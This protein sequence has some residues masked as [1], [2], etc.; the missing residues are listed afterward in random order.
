MPPAAATRP[1]SAG[2]G[3]VVDSLP[4]VLLEDE[5]WRV[6]ASL[7]EADGTCRGVEGAIPGKECA[8]PIIDVMESVPRFLLEFGLLLT[9]IAQPQT[10][11]QS[12]RSFSLVDHRVEPGLI[13]VG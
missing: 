5:G 11:N 9:R 3:V 13:R 12:R 1:V 6:D 8:R 10:P 4:R 7:I 2:S